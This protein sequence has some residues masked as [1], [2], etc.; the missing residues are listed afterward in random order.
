M[1]SKS[2]YSAGADTATASSSPLFRV[3]RGRPRAAAAGR[4]FR[5]ATYAW[6]VALVGV[7]LVILFLFEGPLATV[8]KRTGLT[9][10]P[11]SFTTMYFP[12]PASLPSTSRAGAPLV[13]SFALR[14]YSNRPVEEA[15]EVSVNGPGLQ[16]VVAAATTT[17]QPGM[18]ATVAVR[19]KMPALTTPAVVRVTVRGTDQ[20][21]QFFVGPRPGTR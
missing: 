1:Q 15:W 19:T 7:G 17:V 13:F 21:L 16:A 14:S 5:S 6:L 10:R 2:S 4:N 11:E 18:T 3:S 20:F 9:P 8:M 12:D